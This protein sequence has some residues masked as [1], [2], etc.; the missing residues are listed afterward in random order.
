MKKNYLI[1]MPVGIAMSSAQVFAADAEE[2][3][4]E[5]R[6]MSSTTHSISVKS[7]RL[8]GIIESYVEA[9][10]SHNVAS[11]VTFFSESAV[12]HDEGEEFNGRGEIEEW[13]RKTIT[14]YSFLFNPIKMKRN[15]FISTVEME[16]S[17][18]FDGS[19]ITLDY[20]FTFE[21]EKIKSLSIG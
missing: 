5:G 14:T 16:V 13:I 18:T 20:H 7:C 8:P 11:I 9:S 10:N 12:V 21:N 15:D 6:P 4:E 19:P 2:G 3:K 17:G 1:L